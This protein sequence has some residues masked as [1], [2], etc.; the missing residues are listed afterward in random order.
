MIFIL[1]DKKRQPCVSMQYILNSLILAWCILGLSF[2]LQAET[3]F[4]DQHH[5]LASDDNPGTESEPFATVQK[6]I[7]TAAFRDTVFIKEGMYN[8]SGFS[9]DLHEPIYLL[10]EDKNTT[11]LDSIGTLHIFGTSD[12]SIFTLRHVKFSNYQG[13]VFNLNVADGDI[14]DGITITDCIFDPVERSSKTR[15]FQAR[16]EVSPNAVV[17]NIHIS[18]CDFLGLTAPGVKYIYIYEGIISDILIANNN[19]YKLISNSETRGAIAIN[20]G[21]NSNVLVNKNILISGNFMD[22]IVASSIGEIETHGILAYGDSMQIVNNTVREMIPGTDH[23]GIYMK[24]SY[25]LIANNVMINSTSHQGAIAIKGAGKSFNDT[26]RNNRVQS[27]QSGRGIY[28]AGPEHI[29]MEDNYVKCTA[30]ESTN[31]LYIYAA[32]GTPCFMTN[33]Y[34]QSAGVSAYLHDVIN[35]GVTNNTLISYNA[36]T[37]KLTGS[38]DNI[39]IAGNLEYNGWPYDAPIAMATADIIEG[40]IPLTVNFSGA[41]SFDPNGKIVSYDWNFHDGSI[42]SEQNPNHTFTEIRT[43]TATLIITDADGFKDMAYVVIRVKEDEL[44]VG[45]EN[46][47]VEKEGLTLTVYPNPFHSNMKVTVSLNSVSRIKVKIF[48]MEGALVKQIF[49]GELPG[50]KHQM[51]W[52]GSNST[53][54]KLPGGMYLIS[55]E[56]NNLMQMKQ[57]IFIK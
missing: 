2:F 57:V 53:G 20:I 42:S 15:V 5:P 37:I 6:G 7:N 31:G 51:M 47:A 29:L 41:G 16:Y 55:C 52:D 56:T 27:T 12:T 3:Y 24:G 43:Y 49:S 40:E 39:Y 23:E 4:V 38:S 18:N 10:G 54:E 1:Y 34:S 35:G 36:E 30:E 21:T 45:I 8:L 9:K 48:D 50:G 11:I 13:T 19:F 17:T 33:N 28:T 26:I 32:N 44:Y 14:I 25:S 46:P 22:T